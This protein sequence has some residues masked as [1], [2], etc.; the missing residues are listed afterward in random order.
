MRICMQ[1]SQDVYSAIMFL[2]V[3][4]FCFL[5]RKHSRGKEFIE[6]QNDENNVKIVFCKKYKSLKVKLFNDHD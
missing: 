4:I 3:V 5:N 1:N 6:C 2:F